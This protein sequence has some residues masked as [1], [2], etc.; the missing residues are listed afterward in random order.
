MSRLVCPRATR[1]AT[2]VSCEVRVSPAA[3]PRRAV[4]PV[5]ASAVS[6]AGLPDKPALSY[7]HLPGAV[8]RVAHGQGD[9][10]P[11]LVSSA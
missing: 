6:P 7:L 11:L 9:H 3:G 10:R 5:A 4:A 8:A 1:S 2:L